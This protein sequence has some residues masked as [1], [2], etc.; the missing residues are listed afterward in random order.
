MG[1]RLGHCQALGIHGGVAIHFSALAL[2]EAGGFHL[3]S[4]RIPYTVA[5]NLRKQ[6]FNPGN[7]AVYKGLLVNCFTELRHS[8]REICQLLALSS[9]H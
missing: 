1:R 8:A 9:N 2:I 3:P 5:C 7:Q 6:L 4:Q